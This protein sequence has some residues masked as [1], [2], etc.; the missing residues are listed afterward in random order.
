MHPIIRT[1]RTIVPPVL[2]GLQALVLASCDATQPTRPGFS[3]D[4]TRPNFVLT[5][6][7]VLSISAPDSSLTP[8]QKVQ[9]SFVAHDPPSGGLRTSPNIQWSTSN[10]SIATISSTG[11]VTAG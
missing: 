8:G 2:V 10:S 6:S 11:L 9:V 1:I 7:A 3:A 5:G 4:S